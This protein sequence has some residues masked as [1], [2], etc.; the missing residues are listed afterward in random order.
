MVPGYET[1]MLPVL[2][3]LADGETWR[4]ADIVA[5]VGEEFELSC[6]FPDYVAG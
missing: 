4:T 1:L 3:I 6:F 2:K 5:R